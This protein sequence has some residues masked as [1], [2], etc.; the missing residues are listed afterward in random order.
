MRGKEWCWRRSW[1]V[2]PR[3]RDATVEQEKSVR[4]PPPEEKGASEAMWDE[5]PASPIRR[6]PGP[7]WGGG[8][9]MVSKCEGGK[10]GGVGG[11]CVFEI[12]F[13]FSFC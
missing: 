6:C 2:D 13:S 3:E 5:V 10:K 11:R 9:G 1:R 4:S 12:W 7:L 8:G